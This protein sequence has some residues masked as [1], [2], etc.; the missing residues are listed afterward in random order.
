MLGAPTEK[1]RLPRFS[2]VL[3]TES[4][5]KVVDLSCLKMFD[6]CMRLAK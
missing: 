6:I 1:A 4:C 3:G 2:E 5:N